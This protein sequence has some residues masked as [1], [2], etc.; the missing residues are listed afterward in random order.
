MSEYLRQ[1]HTWA[2][3]LAL[4]RNP[5]PESQLIT[6]VLNGLDSEYLSIVVQIEAHSDMSW[7]ALQDILLSFD[8]R[9]ERLHA[10]S[11]PSKLLKELSP[12]T[13][14][15]TQSTPSPSCSPSSGCASPGGR[16]DRGS[17][18]RSRSRGGKGNSSRPT[19]Q[20]CGRYGHS[21]MVCNNLFDESYIGSDPNQSQSSRSQTQ[22]LL[23]PLRKQSITMLDMS[24]V[25]LAITSPLTL[26]S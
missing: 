25:G 16:S 20:V 9:L 13:N 24:I 5:Y 7:H 17:G 12:S 21:G 18:S 6:N 22:L 15:A 1:M 11:P 8:S 2:D 10:L 26:P 3:V 14:V 23:L 4:A 19:C